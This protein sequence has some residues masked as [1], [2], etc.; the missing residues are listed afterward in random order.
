MLVSAQRASAAD[1][2]P[3]PKVVSEANV[4]ERLKYIAA[5][6]SE[7][8]G[9]E[10]LLVKLEALEDDLW[11][12]GKV[13]RVVLTGGPC[14]GKSTVMSD[15]TQ[16]L[17][18]RNYLVLTM[19]E[20]A[21]MM[22]DWSDGKMWDD[23][24]AAGPE[25]DAVWASLQTT[26]T[27][28]Q[29]VVEDSIVQMA[30]R[31]LAKRRKLATPPKG[32]VVLLDRGVIDNVAYC[33]EEA[34][35]MVLK[36]LGTTTARLRDDRYDHIIHLASAANGAES[37]YTLQQHGNDGASA[38]TET[39]EQARELDVKTEKAWQGSKSHFIVS[40]TGVTFDQ[41]RQ[42][43]R[44]IIQ[45]VVGERV[46]HPLTQHVACVPMPCQ[47]MKEL[48]VADEDIAWAVR[49][50]ACK[51]YISS[52]ARLLKRDHEDKSVQYFVQHLNDDGRVSCQYQI[53]YWTY[54]QK[55]RTVAESRALAFEEAGAGR[56]IAGLKE[57]HED[58]IVFQY[59]GNL[60]R[61]KCVSKPGDCEP[62]LIAQVSSVAAASELLPRWLRVK[63]TSASS[64][65]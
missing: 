42:K 60:A 43:V 30:Y 14:A 53:D 29:M 64:S 24:S 1:E 44:D 35:A 2:H 37:F 56:G 11:C 18:E 15:V 12:R 5:L 57:V 34:W 27:R 13:H 39:V 26:L 61:C 41:K 65:R 54:S 32:V 22:Y 7:N 48:A 58:L 6:A 33:T 3:R 55:L 20:I 40:N 47:K 17:K 4:S 25:D 23:F 31:A 9:T 16:M 10:E 52:N 38:R 59:K 62:S 21:T 49:L 28:V 63:D 50:Q 19:P 51:T 46:E 8:S 36:E 45:K